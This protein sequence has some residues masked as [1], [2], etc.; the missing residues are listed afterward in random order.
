MMASSSASTADANVT[1]PIHNECVKD[2]N[3]QLLL[4][5]IEHLEQMKGAVS[6]TLLDVVDKRI[7]YPRM[8]T[9]RVSD[10]GKFRLKRIEEAELVWQTESIGKNDVENMLEMINKAKKA[11]KENDALLQR[12]EELKR[13]NEI[14]EKTA[15]MNDE[16]VR[17]MMF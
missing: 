12:L 17:S 7:T 1:L 13:E 10:A 6:E 8:I 11:E 4:R 5:K 16:T 15:K 3:V 14:Y 9:S 2:T